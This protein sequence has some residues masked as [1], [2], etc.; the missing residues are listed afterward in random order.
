MF[1]SASLKIGIASFLAALTI[2]V[3]PSGVAHS[4]SFT[5]SISSL[6]PIATIESIIGPIFPPNGV[7]STFRSEVRAGLTSAEVRTA[8]LMGSTIGELDLSI[9]GKNIYIEPYLDGDPLKFDADLNLRLWRFG[10]RG[11]Y[12]NFTTRSR[13]YNMGRI[14]LSGASAGLDIDIVQLNW[15]TVG[16][17]ADYWLKKPVFQGTVRN[18]FN[19]PITL[20]PQVYF[21]GRIE[22]NR[23][24]TLGGY[25]RYIPPEIMGWPLHVEAYIKTPFAGPK[26]WDWAVALAFRPQIYRFDASCKIK[27]GRTSLS[28]DDM[29]IAEL[30]TGLAPGSEGLRQWGLD[31]QWN[32]F[33]VDFALYF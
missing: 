12:T 20:P 27:V 24:T 2:V 28:F 22:G 6:F 19:D 23:P 9:D 3:C 15:L 14:D 13:R 10:L 11:E 4:E 26:L 16:I 30:V 1:H 32:V 25:F 5:S 18:H 29:T 33:G 8:H 31:L 17:C 7:G 21:T